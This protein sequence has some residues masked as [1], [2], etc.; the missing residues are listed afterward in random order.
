M[1]RRAQLMVARN[2]VAMF[3]NWTDDHAKTEE[4]RAVTHKM[5]RRMGKRCREVFLDKNY[6][7]NA[8][9]DQK[10]PFT[11]YDFWAYLSAGFLF[12]FVADHVAGT[13]L[14]ARKEWTVV[15]GIV[16]LSGAYVVGQLAASMSSMIFERYLV[17]TFLGYPR[18]VLFGRARAWKWIR[19]AFS[20]YFSPLPERTQQLVVEKGQAVS[21]VGPSDALFWAAYTY[22]R[23]TPVVL[24]KLENFLN[25]Y[26]FCRNTALV[27]FVDAALLYWSYRWGRGPVEYLHWS[28]TA[29]GVGVG[30]TL[31]YLKFYR[32]FAVEVF[33]SFE[34]P[35]QL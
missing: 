12:L 29:F 10:I 8:F 32:H 3:S 22:A 19:L 11:N 18:E 20:G 7:Y 21:V 31:R 30:M 13:G 15:Q 2:P 23:G 27:A 33:T 1:S 6:T 26:A 16:A 34:S 28:W 25:Q 17:G 4:R 14:L 35:P 5:A 9:M 24:A